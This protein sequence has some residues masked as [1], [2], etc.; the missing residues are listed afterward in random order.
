MSRSGK[1][2]YALLAAALIVTA[3]GDGPTDPGNQNI[4]GTWNL[5]FT[6]ASA[7][8]TTCDVT[9]L[10]LTIVGDGDALSGNVVGAGNGN[11]ACSTSGGT[12]Y[13]NF[14]VTK[15]LDEVTLT[16]EF[17]R[18]RVPYGRRHLACHR[19]RERQNDEGERHRLHLFPLAGRP[20]NGRQLECGASVAVARQG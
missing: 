7:Q 6:D 20:A 2:R 14:A 16:R 3:C 18:L 17:R 12:G 15:Q 1:G 9:D 10:T 13:G 11:I 4:V 8:G 5:A 19:D